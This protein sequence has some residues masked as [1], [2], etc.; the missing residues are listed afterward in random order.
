MA[1]VI[2][3]KSQKSEGKQTR[4]V[5]F[6]IFNTFSWDIFWYILGVLRPHLAGTIFS[7]FTPD[8]G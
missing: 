2:T 7:R 5:L 3:N 4:P 1:S 6:M 8:N